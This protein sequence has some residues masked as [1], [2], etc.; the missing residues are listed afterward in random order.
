MCRLQLQQCLHGLKLPSQ[1]V[2]HQQLLAASSI[3]SSL[4]NRGCMG[5]PLWCD[6]LQ[7]L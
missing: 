3:C 7:H 2:Q 1:L 5:L 6:Q 4:V